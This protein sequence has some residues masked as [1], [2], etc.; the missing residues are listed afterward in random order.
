MEGMKRVMTRTEFIKAIREYA[1]KIEKGEYSAFDTGKNTVFGNKNYGQ[2]WC[3]VN[4]GCTIN[5]VLYH[6]TEEEKKQFE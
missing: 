6:A 2:I 4:N 3:E 1:D 5:F